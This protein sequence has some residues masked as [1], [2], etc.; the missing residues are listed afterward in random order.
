MNGTN[1][2]FNGQKIPNISVSASKDNTGVVTI[3][4]VNLSYTKSEKIDIDLRGQTFTSWSGELLTSDKVDDHNSFDN[5][6]KITPKSIKNIKYK[7][8]Y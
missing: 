2:D 1:Y 7:I 8:I 3:S 4:V 5:A 6:N